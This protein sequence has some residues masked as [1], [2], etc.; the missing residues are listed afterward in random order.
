MGNFVRRLNPI[1]SRSQGIDASA[2]S[3]QKLELHKTPQS[4][5]KYGK[6]L[7]LDWTSFV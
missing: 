7:I 3:A 5:V 4:Y 1:L 2:P 6:N